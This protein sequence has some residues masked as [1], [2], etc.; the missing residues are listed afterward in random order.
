MTSSPR[1]ACNGAV[2]LVFFFRYLDGVFHGMRFLGEPGLGENTVSEDMQ[3]FL[4][5]W[6]EKK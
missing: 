5:E 4:A 2:K 1:P 6:C 3:R